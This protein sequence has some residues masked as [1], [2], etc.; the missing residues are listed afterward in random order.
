MRLSLSA[1]Y[2]PINESSAIVRHIGRAA[3]VHR[4]W[5]A[6]S[7]VRLSAQEPSSFAEYGG[8]KVG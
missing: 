1:F 3:R 7:M 4:K 6:G 8:E 5:R 2:N